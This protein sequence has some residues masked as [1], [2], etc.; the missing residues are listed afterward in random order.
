[1]DSGI[2]TSKYG[3]FAGDEDPQE[4]LKNADKMI[5]ADPQ[6]PN[7]YLKKGE[8]CLRMGDTPEA[9]SSYLLAAWYLNRDGHLDEA[10]A[11][12]KMVLRYAPDN[13]EAMHASNRILMDVLFGSGK[14]CVTEGNSGQS[15]TSPEEAA[16]SSGT[17][18]LS[19]FI[20]ELEAVRPAELKRFSAG[21]VVV[22]EGDAGESMYVIK[23]G[24]ASV[25]GHFSGKEITLSSLSAGDLF[26]E[27]AFFTGRTRTA[28]V[29]A[30]DDLEVYEINRLLFDE[31]TERKPEILNYVNEVFLRRVKQTIKKVKS[32]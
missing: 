20:G 32:Q 4:T 28:S 27:V 21:E 8:I 11:V 5:A 7:H 24:V 10:L 26:G 17:F 19:S 14:S 6:N 12:Y 9:V 16:L 15:H 30:R 1:M 18:S 23:K 31:V 3:G 25:V 22:Y 29:I 13:D 2:G